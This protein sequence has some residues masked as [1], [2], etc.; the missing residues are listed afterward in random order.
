MQV[1]NPG[2]PSRRTQNRRGLSLFLL[3][4]LSGLLFLSMPLL[5]LAGEK[6]TYSELE[7]RELADAPELSWSAF[8]SGRYEEDAEEYIADQF[9]FRAQWVQLK[10]IAERLLGKQES[11]NILLASDGYLIQ[12]FSGCT[13]ENYTARMEAITAFTARH[14]E[15]RHW[16]L[17][18]PTAVTTL[19][20][21]LPFGAVGT[22][23]ADFLDRL[24]A[25]A[26]AAG[27]TVVDVREALT[28][29]AGTEQ[30]YYRTDHHWTTAGAYAAYLR[31]AEAAGL[32]GQETAYTPTLISDSFSGTLTA[33]SGF[34]MEETDEL[35]LY[36]PAEEE[37]YIV[38]YG[39]TGEKSASLYV[40]E[41]LDVRDQYTVF[42]GGNHPL[43]TI[44]TAADTGRVLLLLKD[45]YA[46]CFVPFLLGDYDKILM[47]D[48]RYYAD[49]LE[50]LIASNGVTDV[51]YLY[52]ANN[53][54]AD[55]TL[56]TV[57]G[58]GPG[59]AG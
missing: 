30:V 34:R 46:N 54:A 4:V 7:N 5:F 42:F 27:V 57:L 31:F 20:D 11:N 51:L 38:T 52:S 44:E 22:E 3:L 6:E 40:P 28:E 37:A 23:E 17:A 26:A 58:T 16:L 50:T 49:D 55:T 53:L 56:E 36:L 15:L 18:A 14:P 1:T 12:R 48:P 19:S 45:S 8:V 24:E 2:K 10:G 43:V 32:A 29:A 33:S 21:Q 9:P 13:E 41:Q 47:V 59:E 25:D 39:D 35:Y